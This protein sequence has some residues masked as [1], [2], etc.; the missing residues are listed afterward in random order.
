MIH[1]Y[2]LVEKSF[3][4]P[5]TLYQP[6]DDM[7]PSLGE[8]PINESVSYK[9]GDLIAT[10]EDDVPVIQDTSACVSI[11]GG[12]FI[13]HH[14]L[15]K[16]KV[17]LIP[18]VRGAVTYQNLKSVS[19]DVKDDIKYYQKEA[20]NTEYYMA[21]RAENMDDILWGAKRRLSILAILTMLQY[22]SDRLDFNLKKCRQSMLQS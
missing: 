17:V 12:R 18:N 4:M 20:N 7:H 16:D 1:K 15:P 14:S 8:F 5:A 10:T 22:E 13:F 21:K 6:I 2:Y 11:H 9:K 3:K 19:D